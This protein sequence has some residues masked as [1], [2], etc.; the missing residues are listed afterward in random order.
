MRVRHALAIG[1]LLA[2]L[3]IWEIETNVLHMAQLAREWY[4]APTAYSTYRSMQKMRGLLSARRRLS[5]LNY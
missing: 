1:N 2:D 4:S 5:G 3:A